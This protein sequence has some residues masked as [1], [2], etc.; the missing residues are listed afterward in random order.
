[1]RAMDVTILG[2]DD[3]HGVLGSRVQILVNLPVDQG[4]VLLWKADQRIDGVGLV[5]KTCYF[6]GCKIPRQ[7]MC[8]DCL[9][10]V[11]DANR[12]GPQVEGVLVPSGNEGL[13]Q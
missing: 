11:L 2:V 7:N 1:M 5:V 3:I 8:C 9:R 4:W 13:T 10:D 6:L 12:R